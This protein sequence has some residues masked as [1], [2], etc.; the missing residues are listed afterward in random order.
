MLDS[1]H[2]RAGE[3]L[4]HPPVSQRLCSRPQYAVIVGSRKLGQLLKQA[5]AQV[6]APCEVPVQKAVAQRREVGG[7]RKSS[8]SLT[9]VHT[10]GAA[11]VEDRALAHCSLQS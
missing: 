4:P 1:E 10:S 3:V 6:Q 11:T 9:C 8:T 7:Q 5:I 2:A